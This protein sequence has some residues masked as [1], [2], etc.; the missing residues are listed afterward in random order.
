MKALAKREIDRLVS[1]GVLRRIEH[2]CYSAPYMSLPKKLGSVH[3][4][5]D[6]H[7]LNLQ[8]QR[9][10]YPLPDVKDVLRC[11]EGFTYATCFD[12]NM[13]YCHTLLDKDSQEI[14]SIILLWG[15]YYYTR[16]P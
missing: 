12:V 4:V 15:K 9:H 10:P 7:K 1:S 3:F 6:F 5:T 13:G 11:M 2:S 14:Y 16:L 8:I